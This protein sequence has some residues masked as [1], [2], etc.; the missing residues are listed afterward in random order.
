M[1]KTEWQPA[2]CVIVHGN[3]AL[4][5]RLADEKDPDWR[6]KIYRVRL[7]TTGVVNQHCD[8]RLLDIHPDDAPPGYYWA[9]EHEM[10]TD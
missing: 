8:G 3:V 1:S 5:E 6:I 2:R 4:R 7:N 9:C 10:L